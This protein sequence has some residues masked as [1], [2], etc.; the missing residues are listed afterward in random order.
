[1]GTPLS[2]T[3]NARGVAKYIDS[4]PVERYISQTVQDRRIVSIKD[5]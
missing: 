5:E 1:V 2:E 4:G 3:L